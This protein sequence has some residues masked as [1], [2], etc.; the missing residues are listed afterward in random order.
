MS[1]KSDRSFIRVLQNLLKR[2]LT[3]ESVTM[4]TVECDYA[5]RFVTGRLNRI[6][7]GRGTLWT[8]G[9]TLSIPSEA[10]GGKTIEVK[11][12]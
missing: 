8:F 5:H 7:T 4:V 2:K 10:R 1:P 12:K 6:G 3:H 11:V 9:E